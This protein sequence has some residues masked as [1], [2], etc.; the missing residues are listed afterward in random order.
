MGVA[1]V[2]YVSDI[3][4]PSP[5]PETPW[6][7]FP[8]DDVRDELSAEELPPAEADAM[9]VETAPPRLDREPGGSAPRPA[10]ADPVVH[11]FADEHPEIPDTS[12]PP[13]ADPD[14]TP[15][16]EELLIRQHYLPDDEAERPESD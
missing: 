12:E 1:I 3:N 13:T 9:H 6:E 16:V 11:Y 4:D 8:D 5:M 14:R 15:E 10:D 7:F 2:A